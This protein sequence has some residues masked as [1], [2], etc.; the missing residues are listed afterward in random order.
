VASR[1]GGYGEPVAPTE[2]K[3]DQ[4]VRALLNEGSRGLLANDQTEDADEVDEQS[5][6]RTRGPEVADPGGTSV[7]SGRGDVHSPL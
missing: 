1:Q 5:Q 6:T 2:S 3:Y 4:A 7:T